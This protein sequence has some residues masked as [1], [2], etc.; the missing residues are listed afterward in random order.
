MV[1]KTTQ[2]KDRA[3]ISCAE[4]CNTGGIKKCVLNKSL[5]QSQD[6]HDMT[7][8]IKCA[9]FC[10][11]SFY[12][13][14]PTH[15][16]NT[17]LCS[18]SI[19][20][21][22]ITNGLCSSER[23]D[24]MNEHVAS[25]RILS[26]SQVEQGHFQPMTHLLVE[27][28]MLR[29]GECKYNAHPASIATLARQPL[30]WTNIGSP[31]LGQRGFVNWPNVGPTL[32]RQHWPNVV[33]TSVQYWHTNVG[34]T[35]AQRYANDCMPMLYQHW[36]NGGCFTAF[37]WGEPIS[38][39]WIPLTK[40]QERWRWCLPKQSVEQTVELSNRWFETPMRSTSM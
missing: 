9:R 38:H 15:C 3:C 1:N 13:G 12:C 4:W 18:L 37:L 29:E 11:A 22:Y 6:Y 40:G 35:L 32:A 14:I 33:S 8:D 31:T 7:C 36:P 30:R 39:R 17:T 27:T 20:S 10:S 21:C 25:L 16:G 24:H 5:C 2:Q 23:V 34:P 28:V 26:A 19:F